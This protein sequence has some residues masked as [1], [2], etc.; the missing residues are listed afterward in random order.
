[1]DRTGSR[2]VCN[3]CPFVHCRGEATVRRDGISERARALEAAA[4]DTE[5]LLCMYCE[6]PESVKA[7][8]EI[9]LETRRDFIVDSIDGVDHVRGCADSVRIAE[10]PGAVSLGEVGPVL[11][12][13]WCRLGR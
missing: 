7:A 1:M 10:Y 9:G 12:P 5:P 13:L 2:S 8:R 3:G 4:R 11:R 6:H